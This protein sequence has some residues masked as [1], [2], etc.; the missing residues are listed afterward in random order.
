MG[1]ARYEKLP[2]GE[3]FGLPGDIEK[4]KKSSNTNGFSISPIS[5]D[6]LMIRF[7]YNAIILHCK[8]FVSKE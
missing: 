7:H 4:S 2:F 1:W 5:S 8:W 3:Y 6:K